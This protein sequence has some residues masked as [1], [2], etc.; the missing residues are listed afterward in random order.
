MICDVTIENKS[1]K[2]KKLKLIYKADGFN[3][4]RISGS[5]FNAFDA[6]ITY[7]YV[8]EKGEKIGK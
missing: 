7:S 1:G 2:Q 3:P 8:N 4:I 6:D 5:T